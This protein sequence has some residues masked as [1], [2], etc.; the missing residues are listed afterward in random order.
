MSDH[1]VRGQNKLAS[2]GR[3]E[4]SGVI[5]QLQRTGSCQRPEMPSDQ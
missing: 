5:A 3:V 2:S 1:G 4:Q